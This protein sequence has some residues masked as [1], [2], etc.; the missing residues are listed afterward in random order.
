MPNVNSLFRFYVLIFSVLSIGCLLSWALF[1][2]EYKHENLQIQSEYKFRALDHSAGLR[3]GMQMFSNQIN[4]LVHVLEHELD[5]GE[6]LDSNEELESFIRLFLADSKSIRDVMYYPSSDDLLRVDGA[7]SVQVLHADSPW[8]NQHINSAANIMGAFKQSIK[9]QKRMTVIVNQADNQPWAYEVIPMIKKGNL[10]GWLV[11]SW[12]IGEEI[13]LVLKMLPVSGQDILFNFGNALS[14]QAEGEL[15][16]AQY[17]HLSR[18]REKYVA[19]KDSRHYQWLDEIEILGRTWHLRYDSAPGF[20]ITHPVTNAWNIFYGGLIMSVLLSL[21]TMLVYRRTLLVQG[22]VDVKTRD[23]RQARH[24]MQ[25][26]VDSLAEGVFDMDAKGA[27]SFI[28]QRALD[29]L[30]YQDASQVMGQGVHE[31]I[32]HSDVGGEVMPKEHC[33]IASVMRSGKAIHVDDEVFWKSD[34]SALPVAYRAT[35]IRDEEDTL[36]GIVV[37]FLDISSQLAVEQEREH[38]RK[39]VEHTQRLESLGVLAGGIAHDFNNLLTSVTGNTDLALRHLDATSPVIKHLNSIHKASRHAAD[40]C[41]QMLAYSGQGQLVMGSLNLSELVRDMGQLLAVSI[42]KHIEVDYK[43]ANPIHLI[44]ADK[45]QIQQVVMN[46]LTNANE[47][48]GDQQGRITVTTGVMDANQ[49]FLNACYADKTVLS[50][51]YVFIDVADSGCGMNAATVG[52]MFEPFFTTKF[53]G[54]GLGMSAMQGIVRVHAGAISVQ[55]EEGQGTCIRVLFPSLENESFIAVEQSEQQGEL[56]KNDVDLA[57]HE[58]LVLVVDDEESLREV[59]GMMLEDMG[60]Q[61]LFAEDGL[62]ALDV[63]VQRI[64]DIDLVVLD[65]TMPKMGG[66]A[67]MEALRQLRSDVPILISSGYSEAQCAKFENFLPKPYSEALFQE[68]INA[69]L[70]L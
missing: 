10:L 52:R 54:R 65:L 67:C 53:T 66:E 3:M 51:H 44:H 49:L 15:K 39:Q 60:Y 21:L 14:M 4:M 20:L 26:L 22:L 42:G 6:V 50:G 18:S 2:Y 5:S 34:G 63:F 56:E 40:L 8:F 64:D 24:R 41:K 29:I 68:K 45:A 33:K 31:L 35:P 17:T 55:S 47:A 23:L 43:L 59:A 9:N 36:M 57:K 16:E 13:E 69:T 28:N 61:V 58:G 46:L 30:G 27:C 38:M 70:N 19:S 1:E 62:Q 12:D 7:P 25:L 37:T 11:V 32:H 48:V